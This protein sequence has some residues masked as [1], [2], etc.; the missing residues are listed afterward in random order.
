[1]DVVT[2]LLAIDGPLYGRVEILYPQADAV[3]TEINQMVHRAVLDGPRIHLDGKLALTGGFE[4]KCLV[5]RFHQQ[6][7]LPK[8]KVRG[9][10]AAEM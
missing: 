6:C 1:M 2:R 7:K 9:R 10:A 4:A 3:E 5:Q 8:F